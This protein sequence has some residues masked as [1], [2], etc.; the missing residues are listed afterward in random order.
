MVQ[1]Y[2]MI[3]LVALCNIDRC[4]LISLDLWVSTVSARSNTLTQ[5]F[6]EAALCLKACYTPLGTI[7]INKTNLHT[8]LLE[9]IQCTTETPAMYLFCP[10]FSAQGETVK[11]SCPKSKQGQKA[12]M[13]SFFLQPCIVH[14]ELCKVFRRILSVL[15]LACPQTTPCSLCIVTITASIMFHLIVFS[16]FIC[17]NFLFFF[18][19]HVFSSGCSGGLLWLRGPLLAEAQTSRHRLHI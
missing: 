9:K 4:H 18:L 19:S 15:L 17:C 3:W 14:G 1:F 11:V 8:E 7:F 2:T 10:L 5:G 16:F 12:R 6:H 13:L